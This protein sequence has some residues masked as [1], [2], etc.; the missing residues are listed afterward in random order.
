MWQ[1]QRVQYWLGLGWHERET[2]RTGCIWSSLHRLPLPAD[3]CGLRPVQLYDATTGAN[4]QVPSMHSEPAAS[5]Q[6]HPTP[7]STPLQFFFLKYVNPA[8][9]QILGNLKIVTT[10]VLLRLCL[11]RRLSLLQWMALVLLMVGATT[12]QVRSG[13]RAVAV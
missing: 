7:P 5:H 9:Y 3:W 2:L 12:S 10:G 13:N 8:T 11:Q 6:T 1:V 4:P